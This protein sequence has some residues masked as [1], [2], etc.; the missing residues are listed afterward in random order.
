MT[1]W[2]RRLLVLAIAT[3]TGLGIAQAE[4]AWKCRAPAPGGV[5]AEACVWGRAYLP[6][7]RAVYVVA[8][9]AL[10]LGALAVVGRRAR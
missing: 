6:L 3:A 5:P 9:G 4:V 1:P 7:T 8:L 2:R 10:A